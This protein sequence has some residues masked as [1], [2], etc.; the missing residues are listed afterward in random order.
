MQQFIIINFSVGHV[1]FGRDAGYDNTKTTP[2]DSNSSRD[3]YNLY[4]LN[5]SLRI[6]VDRSKTVAENWDNKAPSAGTIFDYL[7]TTAYLDHIFLG[8]FLFCFLR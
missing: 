3:I 4:R 7:E 5:L 8:R 1:W 6:F 2:S